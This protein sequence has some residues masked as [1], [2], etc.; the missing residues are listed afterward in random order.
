[1]SISTKPKPSTQQETKRGW[2]YKLFPKGRSRRTV[3]LLFLATLAAIG[4]I[5]F[6]SLRPGLAGGDEA[7]AA[8]VAKAVISACPKADPADP[9][10]REA[11]GDK[12][13]ND[14]F[15]TKTLNSPVI[16]GLQKKN[17]NYD[18]VKENRTTTKLNPMVVRRV[19]LS[20]FMFDGTYKI[21]KLEDRTIVHLPFH[22]RNKLDAGEYPYPYWHSKAKWEAFQF[23]PEMLFVVQ[24]SKVMAMIRAAERDRS[25]EF[26]SHEWDGKWHWTSKDGQ[27]EP[28]VTLFE[29]LF[30]KSNPHIAELDTTYRAFDAESRKL[31]CASCHNPSNPSKMAPLGIMEFPNQSLTLRHKIVK[32][33]EANRMPPAA[34]IG[35]GPNAKF[36]SPGIE[37]EAERQKYLQLARAFEQAGD[38]AMAYEKQPID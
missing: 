3:I 34:V 38:K 26:V 30:S 18:Y 31:N 6:A 29:Y 24:D 27:A 7:I 16:W 1:M 37:N 20:L 8:Q 11:C 10:A 15:L 21:E 25:R 13:V 33:M 4:G 17:G 23:S 5:L 2:F 22:Y 9:K 14:E 32:V 35:T 19:Y 12:M 36:V 28:R